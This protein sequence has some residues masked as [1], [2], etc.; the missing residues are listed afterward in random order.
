MSHYAVAVFANNPSDFDALLAPYDENSNF[1]THIC[2]EDEL[3]AKYKEFLVQNPSWEK[4]GFE[5]YLSQMGYEREDGQIVAKYNDNAKWDWYTLGGKDYIYDLK[6][7]ALKR[8]REED[9]RYPRKKDYDYDHCEDWQPE[10]AESCARFWEV[11]VED[12]PLRPDEEKP[13]MFYKKE[14]YL[15]R[16]GTKERYVEEMLRPIT[17]YAF[18][19]PDGVWHAP[20]DMGWFACSDETYEDMERFYHEWRDYISNDDNPYVNFVDCHI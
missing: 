3:K 16:Y 8:L 6:P 4:E 14:Y 12:A 7:E 11:V 9:E 13:F 2:N 18:I 19:T 20:G 17:P 5:Y 15:E 1:T 10:S